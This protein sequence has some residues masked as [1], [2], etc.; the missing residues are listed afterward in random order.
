MLNELRRGFKLAE[1]LIWT[2]AGLICLWAAF[3]ALIK[4]SNAFY[5]VLL[6][7]VGIGFLLYTYWVINTERK[8]R[9]KADTG[10]D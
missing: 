10:E 2:L 9:L 1:R 4:G 8:N 6:A 7:A 5:V 3:D